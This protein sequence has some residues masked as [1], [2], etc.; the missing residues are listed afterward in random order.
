MLLP[1]VFGVPTGVSRSL[2]TGVGVD[3]KAVF[4]L[5]ELFP[6]VLTDCG[7]FLIGVGVG[8]PNTRPEANNMTTSKINFTLVIIINFLP[9][10]NRIRIFK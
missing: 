1:D 7:I 9:H 8:W 6:G 10:L 3:C 2:L 5:S 4:S